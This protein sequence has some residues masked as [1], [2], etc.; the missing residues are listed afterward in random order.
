MVVAGRIKFAVIRTSLI[1]TLAQAGL[2][3]R[4]KRHILTEC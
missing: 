2:K 4:T 1:R 3:D